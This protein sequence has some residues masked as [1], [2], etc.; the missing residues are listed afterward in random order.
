MIEDKLKLELQC[1]VGDLISRKLNCNSISSIPQ[2]EFDFIVDTLGDFCV[3][4]VN[5]YV[6]GISEHGPGFLTE[7]D[8]L[9]ELRKEQIDSL[10]YTAGLNH[11]LNQEKK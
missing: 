2:E 4:A 5:K 1:V 8:H 11:R 9:R 3:D 7:V 10:F 6:D